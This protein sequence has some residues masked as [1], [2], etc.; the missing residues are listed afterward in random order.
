MNVAAAERPQRGGDERAHSRR[1]VPATH[2]AILGKPSRGC[3]RVGAVVFA[4]VLLSS[5]GAA[6]ARGEPRPT[7]VLLGGPE[8][9][10]LTA[11][12]AAELRALGI[13]LDT[14]VQDPA[15]REAEAA[16]ALAGGTRVTVEV[17]G[18]AGRTAVSVADPVTRQLALKQVLEAPPTTAL[19]TML[20]VRTVEFVRATLLGP[21]RALAVPPPLV[22]QVVARPSSRFE[23]TFASGVVAARGGLGAELVVGLQ[24]RLRVLS[25]VH[26]ELF[27]FAPLSDT[28]VNVTDGSSRS[29]AW[30]AGGG[31]F[32]RW[33]VRARGGVELGLGA[34]AVWV[35]ATGTAAPLFVGRGQS[36]AGLGAALYGRLGG[37]LVL[38]GPISLR[39]D[40][41][42]GDAISRPVLNL[43][44]PTD[45]AA[46]GRAFVAVL[47][48]VNLRW[49]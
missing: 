21:P 27:G 14:S 46:W 38:S 7:V 49:W 5:I 23:S 41:L 12:I 29:A 11:R 39:L 25:R 9:A 43:G 10:A 1:E 17:D 28:T 30:L 33:R 15:Q 6:P 40:A 47:A 34:L 31:L 48:G 18:R 24:L 35:R 4:F 26:A 13:S 20:A 32:T 42:A 37:E 19:D 16:S 22:D 45:Q 8:D 36:D 2:A 3:T 44:E